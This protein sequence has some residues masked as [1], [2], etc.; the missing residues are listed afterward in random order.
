MT[1]DDAG[2]S[3]TIRRNEKGDEAVV[4]VAGEID[5]T[6]ADQFD[7]VVRAEL[8]HS[9]VLLDLREVTFMDSSGLRALDTLIRHSQEGGGELRIDPRL[10]DSVFQ[11]LEL[12]GM[13]SILPLAE[14]R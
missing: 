9:A 11:I 10:S 3:V 12:T 7:D 14:P 13:M 2:L 6:T 5:L 1:T 8:R 4:S